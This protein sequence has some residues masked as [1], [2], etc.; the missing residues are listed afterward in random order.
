MEPSKFTKLTERE[1]AVWN[2]ERLRTIFRI[3]EI[4]QTF[5]HLGLNHYPLGYTEDPTQVGQ[6]KLLPMEF[7]SKVK[8]DVLKLLHFTLK[9]CHRLEPFKDEVECL[10]TT[11]NPK[12]KKVEGYSCTHLVGE[13][14]WKTTRGTKSK[15][16]E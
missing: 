5:Y 9:E 2:A 13:C 11:Y 14:P 6:Y 4:R 16:E 3:P 8:E 10:A 1:A 7:R 15:E 12:D